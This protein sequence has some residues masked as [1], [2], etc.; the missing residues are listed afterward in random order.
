MAGDST[1]HILIMTC[2]LLKFMQIYSANTT[3][4]SIFAL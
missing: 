1:R 3:T 4:A 2:R